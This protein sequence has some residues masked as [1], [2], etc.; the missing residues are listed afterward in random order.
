M[1]VPA[2]ATR[3]YITYTNYHDFSLQ[4]KLVLNKKDFNQIKNRQDSLLSSLNKNYEA[5]KKNPVIYNELD[6][7]YIT[8]VYENGNDDID[9]FADL[10]VSKNAPLCFST[11][12]ENLLNAASNTTETKL[13]V[14]LR[15]QKSGGEILSHNNQVVTADKLNDTEFMYQYF[16]AARQKLINMG[17]NVKGIRFTS[18]NDQIIGSPAS[19]KWV[20]STYKYSDLYGEPYGGLDGLSS[21]YNRW[22]GP[23][24]NDFNNDIHEIETY[25]DKL[26]QDRNWNVFYYL[27]RRSATCA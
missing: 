6:K 23:G 2:G 12:S 5:F 9:K 17:L 26:I 15:I 21:V 1:T 4:K 16:A 18:G 10:F 13:D 8:F 14:A 11:Y 7:A 20:Y 24:L 19:A 3:M 25:I 27:L 22:G